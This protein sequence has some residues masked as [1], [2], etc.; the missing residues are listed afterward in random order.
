[1]SF[2]TVLCAAGLAVASLAT[3]TT[4]LVTPLYAQMGDMSSESGKKPASPPAKAETKLGAGEV[5]VAYS[6][7]SVRGRKIMGALVPY[8]KV[9]RTGANAATTLVTTT[10]LTIDSLAVPAGTYTLY[11]LPSESGWMLIVNKQTKQWGTV[12][13][14]DQDLGRV[15]MKSTSVAKPQEMMSISFEKTTAKSTELHVRW[16]TTDEYV[17]VH[18]AR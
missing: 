3:L 8:G 6:A 18:A 1:M 7:P 4:P 14:Q 5:S 16:D 17:T 10:D 15:P 9:W 12:Y 2:R 13:N 11:T